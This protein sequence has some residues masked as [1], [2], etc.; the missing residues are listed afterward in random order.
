MGVGMRVLI[1]VGIVIFCL[2][3]VAYAA[4][5]TSTY[6]TPPYVRKFISVTLSNTYIL[7]V[8]LVK[9]DLVLDYA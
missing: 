1:I 6:Y 2:N 4:M 9:S 3:H 7:I 5:G 8:A